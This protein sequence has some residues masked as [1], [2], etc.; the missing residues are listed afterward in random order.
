M[1]DELTTYVYFIGPSPDGPIKIGVT[2]NPIKRLGRLQTGTPGY[3][4]ILHLAGAF[5]AAM[6]RGIEASTHMAL[7]F[8]GRRI[9]GEWFSVSLAEAISAAS[10]VAIGVVG[11][12]QHDQDSAL[13]IG[14]RLWAI[15]HKRD[16]LGPNLGY[17]YT[18]QDAW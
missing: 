8:S 12:G 16:P 10:T 11:E 2:N 3:L 13:E 18:P 5:T 4:A 15:Q 17:P 6:A 7:A 1:N 9:R 14:R